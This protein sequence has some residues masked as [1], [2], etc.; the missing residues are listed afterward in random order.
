M[1][2]FAAYAYLGVHAVLLA[3]ENRLLFPTSTAIEWFDPPT[4][5]VVQDTWLQAGGNSI[6]AWWTEPPGWTPQ[7]GAILYAHGN[8][9]N[10]SARGESILRWRN[11]LGQAVLIFD[12]PG[13]GKSSG[14]PNEA[15]C[16][17]SAEA[18]YD[19]LVEQKKVPAAEVLLLG[20]SLGGAMAVELATH[21]PHRMLIL[22]NAFTSFPDMAQKVLPW[23]PARW[24]VSNR[25]DNLRK[26][27]RC[28]GPIFITH[29]TA[30]GL[31]PFSQGERL[32]AAAPAPKRFFRREGDGH[33]HPEG[34][35]FFRSVKSFLDETAP[36]QS[37]RAPLPAGE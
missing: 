1:F 32:F 33:R 35:E 14:T 6:H 28:G 9:N 7:Q 20:S 16:Y 29:G 13:Y 30:D 21:R 15:S 8:G 18:A 3:M 11:E 25:L 5:L 36:R 23:L 34:A 24:L 22:I 37:G 19:F 10:L 12:Y 17:S 4:T 31:V 27:K 26:I 2:G